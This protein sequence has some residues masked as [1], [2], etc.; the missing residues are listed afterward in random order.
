[1]R[2][3]SFSYRLSVLGFVLGGLLLLTGCTTNR[4]PQPASP[5]QTA[6]AATAGFN[7]ADI[8]FMQGMIGHHAQAID[9]AKLAPDRAAHPELKQFADKIIADQSTEIDTMKRLLTQ[10]GAEPPAEGMQG[11]G[12]GGMAMPGMMDPQQ[13]SQLQSLQGEQFDLRFLEMM[14]MHH[15][16]AIEAA[17]QVLDNGQNAQVADLA[18]QI[19]KAQQAEIEQMAAWRQQWSAA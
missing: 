12:H 9:M 13:M 10:A 14:T 11:M 15:Q 19:I 16:G 18:R 7:D 17:Q 8:T 5:T 3:I 6:P 2:R 1:M 4:A